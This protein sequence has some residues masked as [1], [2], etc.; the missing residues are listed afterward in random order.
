MVMAGALERVAATATAS[1]LLTEVCWKRQA[2]PRGL[3]RAAQGSDLS[4]LVGR[5]RHSER[6]V[7]SRGDRKWAAGGGAVGRRRSLIVTAS[8]ESSSSS[9]SP[10]DGS[11]SASSSSPSPS[12]SPS[13]PSMTKEPAIAN[14]PSRSSRV[15]SRGDRK[16]AAGGGAVGRRRSLIVTASSESSSSSSSPRDGS[17]SASSS[18]PSPSPSPS[19]PSMT[20][21]PAIA[22][23]PSRSSRVKRVVILGG[24]G[25]VG[26]S[27]AAAMARLP[28]VEDGDG[29]SPSTSKESFSR[30]GVNGA[31]ARSAFDIVI[32]GRNRVKG[33]QVLSMVGGGAE[34]CECDID[35]KQS[36]ARAMDGMY[37]VPAF[38]LRQQTR[39]NFTK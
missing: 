29:G 12:P 20:K 19:S 31:G 21:E 11:A 7:P 25:R 16:W 26:S 35:D 32:A 28:L 30:D 9:S 5:W 23:P 1:A 38:F 6:P 4:I 2:A 10:R 24:T 14:P 34:F 36:L 39:R 33:E 13:S 27:V 8:S 18:S 3:R 37:D 22:N 15:P 17:A